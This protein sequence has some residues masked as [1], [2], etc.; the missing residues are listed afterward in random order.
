MIPTIN[1][2]QGPTPGG[3]GLERLRARL[4]AQGDARPHDARLRAVAQEFEAVFLQEMLKNSGINTPS[5]N[6]GGGVGEEA[7]ASMLTEQYATALAEK[8]GI[9]LAEHVYKALGGKE[10]AA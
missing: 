9:G 4:N 3:D 5:E 10:D 8:G 6:F 2:T 7:F 1:P